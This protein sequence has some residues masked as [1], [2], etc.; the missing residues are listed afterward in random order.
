MD[1]DDLLLFGERVRTRRN[2]AGFTQEHVSS[3]IGISLRFYQM[4]ER[5]EKSLSLD[6]L[7]KLGKI[8]NV[9]IDYLLF[10]IVYNGL[11]DPVSELFKRLSPKQRENATK[12]L[13]LYAEICMDSSPKDTGG[14]V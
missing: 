2:D 12:I 1:H 6:T 8:L 7:V 4:I 9:S 14:I 3:E 11:N 10:G 13:Q 5:G